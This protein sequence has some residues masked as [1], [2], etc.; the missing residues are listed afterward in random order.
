[1][2]SI[3]STLILRFQK[4]TQIHVSEW[5]Q[6]LTFTKIVSRSFLFYFTPP[7]C[8]RENLT[9]T[10]MSVMSSAGKLTSTR[11]YIYTNIETL[12]V[13][14]NICVMD[15]RGTIWLSCA[16][17]R[18]FRTRKCGLWIYIRLRR[19]SGLLSLLVLKSCPTTSLFLWQKQSAGNNLSLV[20]RCPIIP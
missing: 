6:G 13:F 10:C 14:L 4:G 18:G 17:V 8:S 7:T 12:G 11:P 9:F 2:T 19:I 16:A 3:P 20:R 15:S 1:M 5:G